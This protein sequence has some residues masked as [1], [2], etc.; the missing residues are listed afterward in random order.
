MATLLLAL[1]LTRVFPNN[2]RDCEDIGISTPLLERSGDGLLVDCAVLMYVELVVSIVS[3]S[4]V[5][6]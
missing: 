4:C 5:E 3:G 2:G 1:T 6:D